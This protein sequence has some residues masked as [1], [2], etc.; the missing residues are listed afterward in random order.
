[1]KSTK[2]KEIFT[3]SFLLVAIGTTLAIAQ[4]KA[5]GSRPGPRKYKLID[6]GTL[7]GPGSGIIESQHLLTRGGTLVGFAETSITDPYDP[8][9]VN[10]D[11]LVQHAFEWRHGILTDLGALLGIN[12]GTAQAVN[13]RGF[14]VGN[15]ENGLIDPL[16]GIPENDA[17]AWDHGDIFN[18]GTLGGDESTAFAV[19]DSDHATG[20]ATNAVPD[21]FSFIGGTQTRALLW[22]DGTMKD[23]GTLGGPDSFGQFINS[24]GQIA[25][26]SYTSSVPG[27]LEIP[28]FD[29]FVWQDGK[30]TD[31]GNLGGTAC[32]PAWLNDRGELVGDMDLP[33]DNTFHPFLWDGKKLRDL[34]TFG[35]DLG[36]AAWVN[37]KGVVVGGAEY[38][39]GITVHAALWHKH[40]IKDL[41][42]LSA[43]RCS[44]A[45]SVNLSGEIVGVSWARQG[46]CHE[47]SSSVAAEDAVLWKNDTIFNLNDLVHGHPDLHLVT[48][49]QINDQGEIAGIGVP[50]GV[51][52]EDYESHGH[53]FVLIPCSPNGEESCEA[54]S[55]SN[56]GNRTVTP[57]FNASLSR[58]AESEAARER[59]PST[60][61]DRLRR[62][63]RQ[64]YRLPMG[65][66]Q[67]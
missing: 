35:G 24:R 29:P 58:S 33:G 19:N 31:V 55:L 4:T 10:S 64:R 51:P 62:Q 63:M 43:Q 13:D 49:L 21:D 40:E 32:N 57:L 36:H 2:L 53:V 28:P 12:S 56:I 27:P 54:Q 3:V 8:N 61:P 26:F 42:T 66:T 18:L 5:S 9:C 25:G 16:L 11:C 65:A 38:P 50:P 41:G 46:F 34:G 45:A 14:V 44:A 47:P 23:L 6:L 60:I 1:M 17:V 7:G 30:L 48:A 22:Q 39:D 20:F 59:V 67:K 52:L 15:S 37:N